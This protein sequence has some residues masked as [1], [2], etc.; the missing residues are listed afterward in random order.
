M[1]LNPSCNYL[2]LPKCIICR[3]IHQIA[4]S[5]Y[6]FSNLWSKHYSG[7]KSQMQTGKTPLLS[8]IVNQRQYSTHTGGLQRLVPPLI[9]GWQSI[10][11]SS[12]KPSHI[13]PVQ[14]PDTSWRITVDYHKLN[15]IMT[16]TAAVAPDVVLF[17]EQINTSSST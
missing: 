14:N 5:P 9:Q 17:L 1:T 12:F 10:S 3:L 2:P 8:K 6:W 7:G 15:Q 11:T 4:K 16:P 13:W